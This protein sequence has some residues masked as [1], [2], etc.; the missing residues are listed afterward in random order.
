MRIYEILRVVLQYK[1]LDRGHI[2]TVWNIIEDCKNMRDVIYMI[3][4]RYML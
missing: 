1:I 4:I 2:I 3:D